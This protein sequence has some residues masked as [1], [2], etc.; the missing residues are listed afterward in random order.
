MMKTVTGV[1]ELTGHI[2]LIFVALRSITFF[3][4]C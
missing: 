1:D 3:F 2:D 4:C